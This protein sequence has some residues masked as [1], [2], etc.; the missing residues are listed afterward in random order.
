M[1]TKS[2]HI[3]GP[4]CASLRFDPP[5]FQLTISVL[6]EVTEL[7][8]IMFEMFENATVAKPSGLAH[9]GLICNDNNLEIK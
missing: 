9:E 5:S 7:T 8:F 6:E 1:K 4:L 3:G 2:W